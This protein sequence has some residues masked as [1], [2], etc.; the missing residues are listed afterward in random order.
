MTQDEQISAWWLGDDDNPSAKT[1]ALGVKIIQCLKAESNAIIEKSLDQS[2][3][4][5]NLQDDINRK[6][7]LIYNS[8]G[9]N[10][11]STISS[12]K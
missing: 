1:R 10:L 12:D 4:G 2:T 9:G 7:K 3:S 5:R 6:E 8:T 11:V